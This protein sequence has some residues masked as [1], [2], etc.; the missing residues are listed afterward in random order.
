M[1]DKETVVNISKLAR[2][3]LTKEEIEKY[4]KDLSEILE[5]VEK[6]KEIEISNVKEQIHYFLKECPLRSDEEGKKKYD[7]EKEMLLGLAPEKKDN[8]FK[9]KK[10]I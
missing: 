6:L 7:F 8:Y 4:Q 3:K 9:V 1:I 10:I 2:L 5:Y